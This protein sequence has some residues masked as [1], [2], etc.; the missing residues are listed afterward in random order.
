DGRKLFVTMVINKMIDP[1]KGQYVC[2]AWRGASPVRKVQ[3]ARYGF[4]VS[5]IAAYVQHKFYIYL[6]EKDL[7][8]IQFS[9]SV[10][11]E[12]GKPVTLMCN[13]TNQGN[14]FRVSL[15]KIAWY[16]NNELTGKEVTHLQDEKLQNINLEINEPED[17][18]TYTCRLYTTLQFSRTYIVNG[19]IFV[20][21]A[22]KFLV[23]DAQL[24][25]NEIIRKKGQSA[26]FDCAC[27]GNPITVMWKKISKSGQVTVLNRTE[28]MSN[29]SHYQ[30]S[31]DDGRLKGFW[32]EISQTDFNDRG[33]YKCCFQSNN[34]D[35][36]QTFTLRVK[37]T[38]VVLCQ[39]FTLRVKGTCVVLSDIYS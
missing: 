18:G 8:H 35:I 23:K 3:P 5:Y 17:G 21:I 9:K 36:C 4:G 31:N 16:K 30:F 24:D 1:L 15:N 28:S 27:Q 32:L 2:S 13:L 34:T 38:C 26:R 33:D 37:G 10:T 12:F 39:T 19:Q 20:Q 11:T 6:S 29:D 7:P 22:P 25:D 14:K